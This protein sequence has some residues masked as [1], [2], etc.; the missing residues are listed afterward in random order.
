MDPLA[1][2]SIAGTIVQ[3]VDYGTRLL[4]N[5]HELYR[6]S[7]GTLEANN[8]LELVTIDL[9]ALIAKL[10]ASISVQGAYQEELSFERL[11]DQAAQVAQELLGRLDNLK[12]KSTKKKPWESFQ[13]AIKSAWSERE[14]TDLKARLLG[15]REVLDSRLLFSIRENIAT[16]TMQ[17]S[18]RFDN[19]DR[20]TQQILISILESSSA[21]TSEISRDIRA[22]MKGQT[23]AFAQILSRIESLNQNNHR[24]SRSTIFHDVSAELPDMF[25][26]NDEE[27]IQ[28]ITADIEMLDVSDA[29]EL[30]VRKAVHNSILES[31]RFPTMSSR[32][33]DVLEAHPQT[34]EWAL[35][36][37]PKDTLHE[38]SNLA[39]WL[40]GSDGFYWISGKAGS[41]K[42]TLMKHIYDDYRTHEG[43]KVWA[44]GRPILDHILRKKLQVYD[45]GEF[46]FGPAS[47]GSIGATGMTVAGFYL[48]M[49]EQFDIA[50]ILRL[51]ESGRLEKELVSGCRDTIVYLTARCAGLLEVSNIDG[52]AGTDSLIVFFHRTV[53]DFLYTDLRWSEL[54]L[55]TART[56]FNPGEGMKMRHYSPSTIKKNK[57]PTCVMDKRTKGIAR[58]FIIYAFDGT[59]HESSAATQ[60][61]LIDTF[62]SILPSTWINK[63]FTCLRGFPN[64]FERTSLFALR[65]YMISKTQQ[66]TTE[67][68]REVATNALRYLLPEKDC[69][70]KSGLPLPSVEMVS[71]LL[72]LGADPN[73]SGLFQSPW[74][75]TLQFVM[76]ADGE[77]KLPRRDLDKS[78]DLP[79]ELPAFNFEIQTAGTSYDARPLHLR[80]LEIMK[81]LVEAGA[82]PSLVLKSHCGKEEH[83]PLEIIKNS[84]GKLY[85][86]EAAPLIDLLRVKL[87]NQEMNR[88]RKR[89]QSM[90]DESDNCKIVKRQMKKRRIKKK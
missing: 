52:T 66:I 85:P 46:P 39:D 23:I 1:A 68:T 56:D 50:T 53:R 32:Y 26:S 77:V 60:V 58:D 87:Y 51:S 24:T 3:F 72:E 45:L 9:Q 88:S 71:L 70:V 63:V 16:E 14:I 13:K 64:K 15:F 31:L 8:L 2:L 40:E 47:H 20:Q 41:G 79:F 90:E 74:R 75:R 43:L 38:W 35:E 62:D 29:A 27:G 21:T 36:Q 49:K 22:Q 6:S 67:R 18:S 65:H 37:S 61:T 81:I 86:I 48:A 30:K 12:N 19:L 83:S 28:G 55:A 44:K 69:Y 54:K 7:T 59:K 17:A 5:T 33:D 4:S 11:C 80:Y 82:D 89:E 73:E 34:F 57:L 84:V 10:R 42:S 78:F 25:R 76:D